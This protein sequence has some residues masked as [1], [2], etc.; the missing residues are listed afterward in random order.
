MERLPVDFKIIIRIC[1]NT[2]P[3]ENIPNE[4]KY[5]VEKNLVSFAALLS[6]GSSGCTV[7]SAGSQLKGGIHL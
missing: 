5:E 1:K 7:G 3:I 6:G 2:A 4:L